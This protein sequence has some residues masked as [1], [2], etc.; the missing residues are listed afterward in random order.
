MTVDIPMKKQKLVKSDEDFVPLPDPFPLPKHYACDIEIALKEGKMSSRTRQR[1]I[2]EVAS[3]VLC[4]KKYP[5]NSDYNC[6][7]RS[8][9]KKYPFLKASDAKPYVRISKQLTKF[10]LC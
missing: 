4:Y 6:V 5:T 7:A 10:D 2:S 1:F 9:I 3:A 8:V